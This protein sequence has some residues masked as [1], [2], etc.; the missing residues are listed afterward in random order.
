MGLFDK[1]K[2][3]KNSITG[4]AAN[5]YL[6]SAPLQFGQPFTVTVKVQTH[7]APV[8]ISRAYLR[9]QG[10]EEVE[11]PDVDVV[12]EEDGEANRRRELVGARHQSLELELTIADGQ[13]LEADTGYEWNV[14]V[15][16]PEHASAIY[17]GRFCQH[18]YQAMAGLDCFGN[19]PDSGWVE[20]ME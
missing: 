13:E 10:V 3:I 8:K 2:S 15:Q 6:E 4:G 17:K 16:L 14:D 12:Y 1:L 18:F 9:I 11:V 7:D 19:D 20:L 5:V